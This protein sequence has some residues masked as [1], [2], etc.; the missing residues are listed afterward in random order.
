MAYPITF[1][2]KYSYNTAESGLQV[3]VV[4]KFGEETA[5][6]EAKIDTGAQVCLF[7]RELGEMLG[8]LIEDGHRREFEGIAGSLVAY[9]HSIALHTLGLEFDSM[10]YF[11]AHYGLRRNL[12]GREGWLNKIRLAII[13]YEAE[14]F[15]SRYEE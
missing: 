6:A 3:P 5:F 12:L 14:V 13:D 4:L 11:A 10:V 8:L 2:V 7:R 15:L 1:N 9:G